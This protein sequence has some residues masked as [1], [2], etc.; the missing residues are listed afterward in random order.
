MNLSFVKFKQNISVS[1]AKALPLGLQKIELKCSIKEKKRR[2]GRGMGT[3]KGE[4]WRNGQ[5]K[6]V[7]FAV[8]LTR[9]NKIYALR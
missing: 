7:S 3:G 6:F 5:L 1:P 4:A 8:V 2:R 9:L